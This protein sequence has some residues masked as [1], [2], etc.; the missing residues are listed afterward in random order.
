M[1]IV[2]I[3]RIL[4]D[5]LLYISPYVYGL[6]T[7]IDIELIKQLITQCMNAIYGTMLASLL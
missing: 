3:R 6:Y 2:K 5:M 7:I 1:A 4:V